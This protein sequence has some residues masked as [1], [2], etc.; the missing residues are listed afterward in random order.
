MKRT[1][2]FIVPFLFLPFLSGAQYLKQYFDGADSDAYNALFVAIDTTGGNVWQIGRPQKTIFDSAATFPNVIVTDTINS[3][4]PN[5]TSSFTVT[6]D[7]GYVYWG[8]HAVRWKQKLD[9]DKGRDGGIVEYSLDTGQTW[10]SIFHNP[11]IYNFYG[12]DSSNVD[13]LPSGEYAFTGTDTVWRDIWVCFDYS[14]LMF[15]DSVIFRFTLRSDSVDSV[16]EGWMIDNL[17]AQRTY[18]HTASKTVKDNDRIRVFPNVTTGIVHIEAPKVQ[19]FHIIERLQVINAEGRVV[20]E[21]TNIPVK[22]YIDLSGQTNGNYYLKVKTNLYADTFPVV[23][24][25]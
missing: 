5:D 22:F 4:P 10:H 16:K 15:T 1:L 25:R 9:M 19:Q 6:Y 12:F 17:M 8:I 21:Y 7:P 3:Y 11:H 2:F 18:V 14:Y 20:Q 13:T 23:L 24:S